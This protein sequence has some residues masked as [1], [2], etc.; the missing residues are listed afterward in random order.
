MPERENLVLG[1]EQ[2]G[3]ADVL[4]R[5]RVHERHQDELGYQP[6]HLA[7]EPQQI[8]VDGTRPHPQGDVLRQG[9]DVDGQLG[10]PGH[11]RPVQ[12]HGQYPLALAQRA[13][14]LPPDPVARLPEQ[15]QI[16]AR[17]RLV[18]E[19]DEE[20]ALVNPPVDLGR[21]VDGR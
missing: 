11:L 9:R 17:P 10:R 1:A 3:P 21:E 4:G 16:L 8:G 13:G 19:G 18:N 5:G 6:L 2:G 12:Q 20:V 14:D 7:D 15:M